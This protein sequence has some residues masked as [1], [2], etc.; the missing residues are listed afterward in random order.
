MQLK[1][2]ITI[3]S[4]YRDRIKS[5]KSLKPTI[6]KIEMVGEHPLITCSCSKYNP[7]ILFLGKVDPNTN[8]KMFC[9]CMSFNYEFAHILNDDESLLFPEQFKT[10]IKKYPK[11]KNTKNVLMSCKHCISCSMLI[12][13]RIDMIQRVLRRQT[14]GNK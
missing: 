1:N 6:I 14:I 8:I 12:L 7:K 11:K 10:A 2:N 9:S 5:I 13:K 4:I 3:P